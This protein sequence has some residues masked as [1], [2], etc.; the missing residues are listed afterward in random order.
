MTGRGRLGAGGSHPAIRPSGHPAIRP[1]GHPAIIIADKLRGHCQFCGIV[2]FIC[3]SYHPPLTTRDGFA[4]PCSWRFSSLF[5]SV[6][7]TLAMAQAP[8][9]ARVAPGRGLSPW[10]IAHGQALTL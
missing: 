1:S 7:T 3:I 5:F 2:V 8:A 4:R 9:K 10:C 6:I